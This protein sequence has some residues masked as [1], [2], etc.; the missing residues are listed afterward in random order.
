[1]TRKELVNALENRK[2][3]S[4][5]HKGVTLY[6]IELIE[7]L[8]DLEDDA[9]LVKNEN[10]SKAILLNGADNWNHYSYSGSALIYDCD[11]AERLCCPSE[12]KKVRGGDRNPN[13]CE[14]WLDVQARALSQAY[15][16]IMRC[17]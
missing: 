4:A 14:T 2:D 11:I 12:L 10:I 13:S 5:W 8:Y 17:L 15:N 6:A 9:E 7:S 1:M 3:R 16:R